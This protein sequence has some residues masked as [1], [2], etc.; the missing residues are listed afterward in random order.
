[1]ISKNKIK[2]IRSL[3][4]KKIRYKEGL[5]LAEGRKIVNELLTAGFCP[6][7]IIGTEEWFISTKKDYLK[8]AE[9]IIVDEKELCKA[10]LLQHP[11]QVM[12]IFT[13]P[14][15]NIIPTQEYFSNHLC[16]VLD[17]IQDPGNLGT[18]I[19][20]ADWFGIS[21]IICSK[22]TVDAY[23]PKVVQATMGSIARVKVFYTELIPFINTLP[24]DIP[25]YGTL[26]DGESIYSQSLSHNGIIIMGNEGQGISPSIR[27][28]I[29][30]KLLIPPYPP[31]SSTA[32]SLNV[33]IATAITIAEFRRQ[34]IS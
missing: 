30:R 11:Q 3:E 29:N 28:H 26:L 13:I 12:G 6:N 14:N 17:N 31:D 15:C 20:I 2:F 24:K 22:E 27:Q 32:E 1:M 25:I 4:Y 21:S 16:L 18:I 5:F 23:S 10:S 7:T 34:E 33:A 8:K 19:R 9:L